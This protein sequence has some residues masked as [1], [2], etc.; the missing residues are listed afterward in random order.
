MSPSPLRALIV[1]DEEIARGY[2]RSLLQETGEVEVIGESP[3]GLRAVEDIQQLAPEVVFLD[4]QM[5]GLDGFAAL[6]RLP[7]S[8]MPPIILVTAYDH[9]AMKGFEVGALDYLLKPIDEQR[10]AEAVR[11]AK[12]H[13]KSETTTDPTKDS[14]SKSDWLLARQGKEW[15]PVKTSEIDWIES[16][17]NYVQLHCSSN[18]SLLRD[19]LSHLSERLGDVPFVRVHR[20]ALVNALRIEALIPG[21]HGDGILRLR[22]GEMVAFSRRYRNQIERVFR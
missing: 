2:L 4:V 8:S 6:Q 3:N 11:R 13:R 7:R 5:P 16:A 19:S 12:E 1:D 14:D 21:R 9:F 22:S 20:T 18:V 17:G 10:L 15:I